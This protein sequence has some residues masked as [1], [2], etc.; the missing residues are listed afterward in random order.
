MP[1]SVGASEEARTEPEC[2]WEY[3]P[4]IHNVL[5]F[6]RSTTLGVWGQH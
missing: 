4:S 1:Y 6:L 5:G 3:F 2:G